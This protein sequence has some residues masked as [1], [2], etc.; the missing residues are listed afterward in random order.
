MP[1]RACAVPAGDES[2]RISPAQQVQKMED[3]ARSEGIRAYRM[4]ALNL[5]DGQSIC[6]EILAEFFCVEPP[7]G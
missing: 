2:A 1:C 6:R 5:R 7:P 3:V 4:V